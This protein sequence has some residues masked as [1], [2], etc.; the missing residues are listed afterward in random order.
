LISAVNANSYKE[1]LTLNTN[2]AAHEQHV[3]IITETLLLCIICLN[4]FICL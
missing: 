4:V 3:D 1:S 2:T